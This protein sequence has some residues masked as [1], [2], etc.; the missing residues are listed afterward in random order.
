MANTMPFEA[1]WARGLLLGAAATRPPRSRW[2]VP[3]LWIVA[4]P[5]LTQALFMPWLLTASGPDTG[6]WGP[7]DL[8]T[9]AAIVLLWWMQPLYVALPMA[10][11]LA[12]KQVQAPA[13]EAAPW[14]PRASWIGA[15]VLA[16]PL[17]FAFGPLPQPLGALR[18]DATTGVLVGPITIGGALHLLVVL[19][20]A[21]V[22]ARGILRG[23]RPEAAAAEHGAPGAP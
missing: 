20:V 1:A 22:M 21:W 17:L 12:R 10:A 23:P 8:P 18:H 7:W 15:L 14:R 4:L 9:T 2:V 5:P 11:A 3:A 16:C 19:G 6:G 13:G